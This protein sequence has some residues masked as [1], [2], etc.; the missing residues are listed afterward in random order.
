MICNK[1]RHK[2]TKFGNKPTK[3]IGV[4]NRFMVGAQCAPPPSLG[5]QRVKA[6]KT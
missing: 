2:V 1:I 3:I 5:L 4:A 6:G